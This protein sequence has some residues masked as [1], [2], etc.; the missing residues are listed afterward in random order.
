MLVGEL[1][2]AAVCMCAGCAEIGA[3]QP[4]LHAE[5]TAVG[6]PPAP[7]GCVNRRQSLSSVPRGILGLAL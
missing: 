1:S 6:L 3:R 4:W 7:E 2:R 5:G